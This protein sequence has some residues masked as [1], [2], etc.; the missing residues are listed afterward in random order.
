MTAILQIIAAVGGIFATWWI[1]KFINK[2]WQA[3]KNWQQTNEMES[4]RKQS[5]DD[6]QRANSDSDALRDIDGR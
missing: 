3:Y 1:G 5:Q 2:Y 6:S 4:A